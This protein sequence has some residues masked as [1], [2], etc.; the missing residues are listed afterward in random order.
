MEHI[1]WQEGAQTRS[2]VFFSAKQGK[3]PARLQLA[4]DNLAADAAMSAISQGA[5][6]LWRG[7]YHQARQ[8]LQALARRLDKK[9]APKP[10]ATPPALPQA[11]HQWRMGQ[12]QRARVL[13]ALLL[14][15]DADWRI[16][17]ARAPD[18]QAALHATCPDWQAQLP[19]L[20]SL[21]ELQGIIGAW[22]WRRQGLA[23][24]Q[25]DG[26][27]LTP[28]WGVFA[29]Q[30][31]EYLD[32]L[33]SAPLPPGCARALDVGAGSGVLSVI[34]AKRGIAEI[35]ATDNAPRALACARDNLQQ[36]MPA[37]CRWRVLEADL[38]PSGQDYDLLVCNPPWLPGKAGSSMEAAIYDPD[39][40]MLRGFLQGAKAHLR[41]GGQAWLILSDLAE[42]LRLRSR[43]DLLDWIAQAGL[44]VLEKHDVQPQH[45]RD[46]DDPFYRER[47]QEVSSLWRLGAS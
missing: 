24:A 17:A 37:A 18:V 46:P 5:S 8:L 13:G 2:A 45:R 7:D 30:R 38:F 29:P 11:F 16:L 1:S 35:D 44:Q 47:M 10:G 41:P 32:L 31:N 20:I 25:L 39:S 27:R 4:A 33:L 19:G 6:L 12:A 42:H 22:E 15:V 36:L 43:Q 23:L 26:A 3:A 9:S 34:L 28:H 21:R 14:E 40:R